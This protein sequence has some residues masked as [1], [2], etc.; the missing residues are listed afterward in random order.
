[1]PTIKQNP[2][3]TFQ[4]TVRNKLL[5]KPYYTTFNS[6]E[7]AE[8]Y[9]AKLDGLLKQNIV[10]PGLL[11]QKVE[12]KSSWTISRCIAEYV[13]TGEVK[14]SEIKLLDTIRPKMIAEATTGLNYAW[15]EAWV[16]RMKRE[17]NLS[18][19]TIKHRI[20]GKRPVLTVLTNRF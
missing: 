7:E 13:K 17:E 15:C 14:H 8:E 12:M 20:G 18:P 4:L 6:R 2:S 5:P 11:D 1:M 19:S 10:P 9:G 3:G 16:N